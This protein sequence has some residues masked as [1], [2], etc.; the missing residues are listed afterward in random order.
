MQKTLSWS[1]V[2][3]PSQDKSESGDPTRNR[4]YK[5]SCTSDQG[6]PFEDIESND[7]VIQGFVVS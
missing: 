1:Q 6:G 7:F 2:E 3:A 4:E 5:N